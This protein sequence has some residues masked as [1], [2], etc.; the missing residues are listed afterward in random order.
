MTVHST[1]AAEALFGLEGQLISLSIS[2]DP[3]LLEEL[4]DTLAGLDFPVN[5]ELYHRPAQVTVAFPAYSARLDEVRTALLSHG[6]DPAQLET[7][8]ALSS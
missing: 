2:V 8:G 4:L 1:A 6:F 3:K 7:S 5:P